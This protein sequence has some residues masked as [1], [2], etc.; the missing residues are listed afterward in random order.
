MELKKRIEVLEKMLMSREE[1][2]KKKMFREKMSGYF[3]SDE[4]GEMSALALSIYD[5]KKAEN[6]QFLEACRKKGLSV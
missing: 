1:H 2:R 3:N 4:H 6:E 5:C